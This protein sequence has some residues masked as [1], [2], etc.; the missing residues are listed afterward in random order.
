[1]TYQA[2]NNFHCND[3]T[4]ADVAAIYRLDSIRLSRTQ[5][6]LVGFGWV[7]LLQVDCPKRF[8][9]DMA[10]VYEHLSYT[11]FFSASLFGFLECGD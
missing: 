5:R 1:V 7:V 9:L 3:E 11:F 4:P 10:A 2:Q 8:R 6:G